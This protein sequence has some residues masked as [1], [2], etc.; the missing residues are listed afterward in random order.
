ME[1]LAY[2]ESLDE[3][4]QM[5]YFD[6]P[7]GIKFDA[8]YNPFETDLPRNSKVTAYRDNWTEGLTSY[9]QYLKERL[10]VAKKLL[11]SQG[12]IF[13]QISDT[14]LHHV[15]LLLDEVFGTQNFCSMI[16]FRTGTSLQ[17]RLIAAVSDYLLWYAKN[18][19]QCYCVPLFRERFWNEKIK[20]FDWIKLSNGHI[21]RL[22]AKERDG[23]AP[24]PSGSLFK[25]TQI[26]RKLQPG[27][28]PQS[29]RFQGQ[30]FSPPPGLY[31]PE[32]VDELVQQNRVIAVGSRLYGVRYESDFP[33]VRYTNLW[34][35][36][37]RSTFASRKLYPVQTNPKVI[38]RCL[39]MTTK[40]GELILDPTG[41]SGTTA[42]VA[43]K[44][45]RRWIS[46]DHG[47]I[48]RALTRQ[49]L[50]TSAFEMYAISDPNI[51]VKSGFQYEQRQSKQGREVGG[52]VPHLTRRILT[53]RRPPKLVKL[54][55]RPNRISGVVRA[56]GTFV[57]QNTFQ[58]PKENSAGSLICSNEDPKYLREMVSTLQAVSTIQMCDQ[59]ISFQ[60]V[61]S[62]GEESF[63]HAIGKQDNMSPVAFAF[64]AKF[65]AITPSDI[66]LITQSVSCSEFEKL[67]LIGFDFS[68]GSLS[69]LGKIGPSQDI[70]IIPVCASLDLYMRPYLKLQKTSQIFDII[71]IPHV[72]LEEKRNGHKA[73][74]RL[75]QIKNLGLTFIDPRTNSFLPV[76]NSM[77]AAWFLDTNYNGTNFH[78]RQAFFPENTKAWTK[79]QRALKNHIDSK[80]FKIMQGNVSFPFKPPKHKRVAVK[81]ADFRGNEVISV[82]SLED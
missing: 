12:S 57:V 81:I 23:S 69:F 9:R 43:E 38:E 22:S 13:V 55:D 44:W 42:Y 4:V 14:N 71:G 41:G 25:A 37:V 79:L 76:S 67:F 61:E 58:Y 26:A 35:D 19:D 82:I 39:L 65:K 78:T 32:Y 52:L 8:R 36:T 30:D 40:P 50:L 45:G 3:E 11:S 49:R 1:S 31:Y 74:R 27:E 47:K 70:P 18:K 5:V 17:S 2:H 72:Q 33:F 56:S 80:N 75:F 51:G 68:P 10:I 24:L 7:F 15:R 20:T 29:V 53:N 48:S 64:G 66:Q 28:T 6:P 16:T 59:S 63:P 46:I 54:I 62:L 77:V 21:R 73:N 34:N 60:A